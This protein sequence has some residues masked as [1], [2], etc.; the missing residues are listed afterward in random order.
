MT[1]NNFWTSGPLITLHGL[2]ESIVSFN[3]SD[4]ADPNDILLSQEQAQIPVIC[5]K[6]RWRKRVQRV[7]C[8]LRISRRSNKPPLPSILLANVQ[9]SDNNID[10]LHV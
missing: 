5:V 6:R 2:A 8:L 4:E 9:S 1:E 7:G 3:E 10:D